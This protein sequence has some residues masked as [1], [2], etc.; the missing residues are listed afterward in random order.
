MSNL[1][2]FFEKKDKKR[3]KGDKFNTLND[4]GKKLVETDKKREYQIKKLEDKDWREF[5]E[6]KTD[7]TGLKIQNTT[8]IEQEDDDENELSNENQEYIPPVCPWKTISHESSSNSNSEASLIKKPAYIPP[9]LRNKPAPL[10]NCRNQPIK[11]KN[12]KAKEIKISDKE[13]F[14]DLGSNFRLS[15]NRMTHN[16]DKSCEI[17]KPGHNVA[18]KLNLS[19][20]YKVL[21]DRNEC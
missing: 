15:N 5:E 8:V 21:Q 9:H 18:I 6:R 2:D 11:G 12:E 13:M 1:N 7:F 17:S 3:S 16:L 10:Q 14:P 19:D 4:I 20:R